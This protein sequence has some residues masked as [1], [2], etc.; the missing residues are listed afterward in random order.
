MSGT[1]RHHG[2]TQETLGCNDLL[3]QNARRRTTQVTPQSTS[4]YR[5]FWRVA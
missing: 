5:R 4:A 1:A 2:E 3:T